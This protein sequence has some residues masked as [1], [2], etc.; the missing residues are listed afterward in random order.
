MTEV[1]QVPRSLLVY[2]PQMVAFSGPHT[3]IDQPVDK[4]TT[5]P[6]YIKLILHLQYM[7]DLSTVMWVPDYGEHYQGLS[8]DPQQCNAGEYVL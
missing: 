6:L 2:V 7:G 4:A 3:S 5:N 8:Q 1:C